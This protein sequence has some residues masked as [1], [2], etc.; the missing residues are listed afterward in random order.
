MGYPG[1]VRLDADGSLDRLF[2]LG[3]VSA[4]A[5]QPDGMIIAANGDV[6]RIF[7]DVNQPGGPELTAST[8]AFDET[9]GAAVLTVRRLGDTSR[10]MAV[11]FSTS[12]MTAQADFDY[13]AQSGTLRFAPLQVTNAISITIISRPPPS[14]LTLLFDVVRDMAM[15]QPFPWHAL[16]P[17]PTRHAL[18]V[19]FRH[20]DRSW[21]CH[22]GLPQIRRN[23]HPH[24]CPCP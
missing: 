8:F 4:A 7:P 5:I 1:G 10:E 11:D 2:D 22:L 18:A 12:D 23:W 24:R 6:A 19:T 9:A 16:E 13:V 15:Q 3:S 14:I 20:A 21:R 17:G